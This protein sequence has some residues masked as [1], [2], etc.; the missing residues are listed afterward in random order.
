MDKIK[1]WQQKTE[2]RPVVWA[3]FSLYE[4]EESLRDI[5]ESEQSALIH[6]HWANSRKPKFGK[7]YVRKYPLM[8]LELVEDRFGRL[9]ET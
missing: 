4:G 1:E 3:V 5:Y 9:Y 2:K 7:T 8:N 6:V